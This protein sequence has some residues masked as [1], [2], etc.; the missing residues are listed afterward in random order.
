MADYSQ[1]EIETDQHVWSLR[2]RRPELKLSYPNVDPDLVRAPV[3]AMRLGRTASDDELPLH[4]HRKGQIVIAEKGSVKCRVETGIWMVPTFGAFW[5]PGGVSHANSASPDSRIIC[6]FVDPALSRLPD[7]CCILGVSPLMRSIADELTKRSV[8]YRLDEPSGRLALVL[9]DEFASASVSY[10]HLPLSSSP[11]LRQIAELLLDDPADRRTI[12]DWA[13]HLA[14]SERNFARWVQKETGMTF[15]QW[16]RQLQVLVALE[17]LSSGSS[18][19]VISQDL[20][21]ESTSAFITMFKKVFG[22]SPNRYIRRIE[23]TGDLT[24]ADRTLG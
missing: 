4:R 12:A 19:N 17:R 18:V 14:M 7:R 2:E 15:G 1:Q 8:R 24:E 11:R 13:S 16:R 6:I 21:Y 10:Q 23:A 20:G 22:D 5:V 9:M 3:F